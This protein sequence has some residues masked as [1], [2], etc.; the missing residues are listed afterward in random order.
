MLEETLQDTGIGDDILD[1]TPKAQATKAE[2]DKWDSIKPG[3]FGR[4]K[5]TISK[6]RRKLTACEKI[7]AN[8]AVDRGLI[9]RTIYKELNK[10]RINHLPS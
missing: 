5:R 6:A 1:K 3:R 2:I 10:F 4:A 8:C 9:P 7:F